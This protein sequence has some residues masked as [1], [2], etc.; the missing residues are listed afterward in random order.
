MDEDKP[1]GS[2]AP[3]REQHIK[4]FLYRDHQPVVSPV[5]SRSPLPEDPS[6]RLIDVAVGDDHDPYGGYFTDFPAHEH[7]QGRS[8]GGSRRRESPHREFPLRKETGYTDRVDPT[9]RGDHTRHG[10]NTHRGNEHHP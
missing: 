4:S 1:S 3:R 7:S 5:R 2:Q 6:R 8:G 10:N 9:T